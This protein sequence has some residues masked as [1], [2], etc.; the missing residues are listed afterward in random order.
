MNPRPPFA[1]GCAFS[2]ETSDDFL[3]SHRV[4]A[5]RGAALRDAADSDKAKRITR[6]EYESGDPRARAR[7]GNKTFDDLDVNRDA[8]LTADDFRLR[9]ERTGSHSDLFRR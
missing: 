7:V 1:G 5:S 9:L 8:V 4:G 2:E 3:H 6:A